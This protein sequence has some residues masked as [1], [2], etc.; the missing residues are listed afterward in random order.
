MDEV[1]TEE[2]SPRL[3]L[4]HPYLPLIFPVTLPLLL[5]TGLE[6]FFKEKSLATTTGRSV[7]SLNQLTFLPLDSP[8]VLSLSFCISRTPK[9]LLLEITSGFQ[10]TGVERSL[11]NGTL[12]KLPSMVL[13]NTSFLRMSLMSQ[14]SCSVSRLCPMMVDV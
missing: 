12:K 14:V 9:L 13:R 3:S 8:L 5:M 1:Q 11:I 6:P 2:A 7:I 4:T 10:C